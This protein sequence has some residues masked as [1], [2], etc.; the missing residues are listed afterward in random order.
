MIKFKYQSLIMKKKLQKN[1]NNI[2]QNKFKL[3]N[4]LEHFK[5][6]Y[7]VFKNKKDKDLNFTYTL[8]I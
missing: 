7:F 6:D 3:N 5:K 2:N 1:L 8:Q 4:L